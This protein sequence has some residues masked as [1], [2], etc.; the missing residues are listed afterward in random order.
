MYNAFVSNFQE[1]KGHYS[2]PVKMELE[3]DGLCLMNHLSKWHK[4][5][6]QKFNDTKLVRVKDK[7]QREDT[8]DNSDQ[9]KW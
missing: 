2:L 4:R 7:R 5:C 6:H 9:E 1:F 3:A 8:A